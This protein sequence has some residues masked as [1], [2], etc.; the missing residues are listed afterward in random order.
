ME[1]QKSTET[2]LCKLTLASHSNVV[3]FELNLK[4]LNTLCLV[5]TTNPRRALCSSKGW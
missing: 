1:G 5:Q 4:L 3:R 2:I